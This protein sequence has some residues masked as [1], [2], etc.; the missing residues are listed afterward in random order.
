[1]MVVLPGTAGLTSYASPLVLDLNG[2][3]V[4]TLDM[5]Q[6]T[7][8]DLQATGT[9]Q[10]TGWV[11]KHDGLLA[12]DLNNDGKITSG[13]ELF[14]NYTL[15]TNGQN[16]ADGWAALA[17]YDSNGDGK[18]D[19]QDAAFDELKVWQD[20]NGNG[21]TDAGELR[22]LK[23]VGAASINLDHDHT[24][25]QQ[26]GNILQGFSTFTTT[27]GAT[28]EVVDAWFQTSPDVLKLT[29]GESLDISVALMK[30]KFEGV[31]M[32]SDVASNTV[33]VTLSDVLA[34]G[35]VN[36]V[37]QLTLT[38]GANDYVNVDLADWTKQDETV[39]QKTH[40]YAVYYAA[41]G[42]AAQLLIDQNLIIA[43]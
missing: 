15:L 28:Y 40:T 32:A 20:A 36:G 19:A 33:K 27:D 9:A 13:A 24:V 31:D 11:N 42:S 7:T 25:T 10:A 34:V 26:N 29:G 23:D 3:G 2:D 18:M 21:V 38:G 37:H 30:L 4:Q 12:M 6:G 14:G 17:Q 43:A 41:D 39:T 16:A 35:E 5:A 22:S 8:F 1:M